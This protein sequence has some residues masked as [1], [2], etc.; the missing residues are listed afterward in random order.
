MITIFVPD[1]DSIYLHFMVFNITTVIKR[2]FHPSPFKFFDSSFLYDIHDQKTWIQETWMETWM[3]NL[4]RVYQ[5]LG[6]IVQ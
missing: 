1:R 2:W 5:T 6:F 4:Y 3:Q